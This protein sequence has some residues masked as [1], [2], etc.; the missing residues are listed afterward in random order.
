[1][2]TQI[3]LKAVRNV[4]IA[5]TAVF[6]AL[7]SKTE[8]PA[9]EDHML[10]ITQYHETFSETFR[11]PLDVTPWGPSTWI[12]HTPWHGDF[13][14]ARFAD[15]Q[16]GFPFT[17]GPQGLGIIAHKNGAGKWEAGLLSSVDAYGNGFSQS[18]GYF[19]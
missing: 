14:D 10:N 12:A 16:P 4:A 18:G 6:L 17:T 5:L 7:A 2:N 11:G 3:R 15:P 9:A 1:M 19:E 8:A 13:G